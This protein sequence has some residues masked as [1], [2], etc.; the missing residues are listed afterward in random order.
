MTVHY[1]DNS[2][3]TT[4][5]RCPALWYETYVRGLKPN[6]SGQRD[7]ALCL[8]ALYHDA[9]QAHYSGRPPQP[10]PDVIAEFD[11]TP[12]AL[13]A[14]T[15]WAYAYVAQYPSDPWSV[16]LV[17]EP[18]V[19]RS[20]G[21]FGVGVK[22]ALSGI[23]TPYAL[24]AKVDT[25]V[26]LAEPV[27]IEG[28]SGLGMHLSP[29]LYSLEHKTRGTSKPR[30]DYERRWASDTQ[31]VFQIECARHAGYPVLGVIVNVCDK[32]YEAPPR[33]K[34]RNAACGETQRFDAF[35]PNGKDA[36]GK[37][38]YTCALCGEDSQFA[39]PEPKPPAQPT[40]WRTLVER[41]DAQIEAAYRDF[42]RVA[43]EMDAIRRG[44]LT[45][46]RH[47]T[48]C[49]DYNRWCN[50]YE[51]HVNLSDPAQ[52]DRFVQIEDPLHYVWRGSES[53]TASA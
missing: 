23:G 42:E 16:T 48:A 12:D 22:D 45:P 49:E 44:D 25:I 7:D 43:S 41:T 5:T 20:F 21:P 52:S 28:A 47:F 14:A 33:R 34:C 3:Y 19:G 4:Y 30:E 29:G 1:L 11:P 31:A 53:P 27:W 36:K 40:F 32:P 24:L 15:R 50:Y 9:L 37:P 8:G 13:D 26:E 46:R 17:E 6:Y 51:H 10:S 38:L 35:T 18:L 39:P 2:Q